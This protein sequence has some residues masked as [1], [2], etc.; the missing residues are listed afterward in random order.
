MSL[1]PS[2]RRLALIAAVLTAVAAAYVWQR[3]HRTAPS[4]TTAAATAHAPASGASSAAPAPLSASQVERGIAR[5]ADA[6]KANPQDAAG[7]AM[8]AH[9]H[10]MLGQFEE[11]G[12]AYTQLIA[13]RPDDAQAHADYADA[14][15][16]VQR[17]SL[18][19]EPAKL[20]AKALA[21]DPNNL[22]ALVLG[23]KEAFERK[24]YAQAISLWER[25]LPTTQDPAM[26]RPIETS[27]AEARALANPQASAKAG[28]AAGALGFVSGRVT[29]ADALKAKI[30]PDDTVF[31]FARPAEGSSKMPVALLRKKGS[32]L[33]LDF[34][35]DDTLAMVAQSRL[36]QYPQLKLGVRVSK[37]GDA[38]PVA[39][40]LEGEL[41][42]VALGATGLK[43]EINR[44]HP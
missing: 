25:A 3:Q 21:I 29:V 8:L 40:D 32:D 16:V 19:G 13:L 15:G 38:I 22:K 18:A 20:I 37:R 41:S 10:E 4:E 9:S 33:P 6:V 17:G 42:P 28:S 2:Q 39:G 5:A 43:L 14:L 12:K 1:S 27:I 34:A 35:L 30:S 24:Q 31:I 44:V 7:W 23:G 26:R 36:S 11:A